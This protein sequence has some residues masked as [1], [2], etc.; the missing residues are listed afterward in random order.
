MKW[1]YEGDYLEQFDRNYRG[2]IGN[3]FCLGVRLE[4]ENPLKYVHDYCVD[5]DHMPIYQ[6]VMDTLTTDG[7]KDFLAF[8]ERREALPPDVKYQL[9]IEGKEKGL[10]TRMAG[11]APSEK[12]LGYLRSLGCRTVPA[13]KLEASDLIT[14]YKASRPQP[15]VMR[16]SDAPF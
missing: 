13:T 11:D 6:Q 10:R 1:D 12:Q 8:V 9:K 3:V 7:A 5:H 15:Q 16:P 14:Q 4:P 2:A